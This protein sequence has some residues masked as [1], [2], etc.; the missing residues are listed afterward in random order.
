MTALAT[1]RAHPVVIG[2]LRSDRH[3]FGNREL[4]R[5]VEE[6]EERAMRA[7]ADRYRWR[8]V[9]VLR[10]PLSSGE[11]ADPIEHLLAQVRDRGADA[12]AVSHRAYLTDLGGRDCL[13]IVRQQCFVATSCPEQ[14]WPCTGGV[15]AVA[16][17]S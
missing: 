3:G 11:I 2:L 5:G 6:A 12:V 9:T 17:R 13:E 15:A 16:P 8:M 4:A 14:L 7:M 10:L 1:W